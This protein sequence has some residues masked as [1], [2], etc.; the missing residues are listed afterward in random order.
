M[1]NII[2]LIRDIFSM[3]F[4]VIIPVSGS[5]VAILVGFLL[6]AVRYFTFNR[7]RKKYE[8]RRK[9]SNTVIPEKTEEAHEADPPGE[10]REEAH[11]EGIPEE[12]TT[13][14]AG[15]LPD[16]APDDKEV[17]VQ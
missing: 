4:D 10:Q 9:E 2:K 8:K 6:F 7:N 17:G 5:I 15:G 3:D 12:E 13:E 1:E 11:F 16:K 14:C